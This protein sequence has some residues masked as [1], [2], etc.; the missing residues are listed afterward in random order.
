V[1]QGCTALDP[2]PIKKKK[3]KDF[4]L[5]SQRVVTGYSTAHGF[6]TIPSLEFHFKIT[7]FFKNGYFKILELHTVTRLWAG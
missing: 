6:R 2:P 5:R 4:V 7:K 3:G 1:H